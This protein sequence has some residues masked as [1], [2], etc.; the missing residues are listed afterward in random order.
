MHFFNTEDFRCCGNQGGHMNNRYMAGG[1]QAWYTPGQ[2]FSWLQQE[3]YQVFHIRYDEH[4]YIV[5][6]RDYDGQRVTLKV[7]PTTRMVY[8]WKFLANR[9]FS[10]PS[11]EESGID[12][13]E[14]T[15]KNHDGSVRTRTG[16]FH[17][18]IF[19]E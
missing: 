19:G 11:V 13:P 15:P 5:E 12:T 10:I 16:I 8:T 18:C 1:T 14:D 17:S 9:S 7:N 6:A 4:W 2:I 3:R